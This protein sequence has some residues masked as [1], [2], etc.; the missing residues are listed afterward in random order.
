MAAISIEKPVLKDSDSWASKA[1]P[2]VDIIVPYEKISDGWFYED[3]PPYQHLNWFWKNMSD[4]LIHTNQRGIPVWDNKSIYNSSAYVS[5][6]N[7]LFQSFSENVQSEPSYDSRFW[8]PDEYMRGLKD[9]TID[10]NINEDLLVLMDSDVFVSRNAEDVVDMILDE[11]VDVTDAHEVDKALTFNGTSWEQGDIYSLFENKVNIGDL[12]D[13]ILDNPSDYQIL[14]RDEYTVG[15]DEYGN[16]LKTYG[17]VN[18]NIE[19]YAYASWKDVLEKPVT[20]QPITATDTDFGGIKIKV[21]E[22]DGN[23]YLYISTT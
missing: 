2:E 3:K 16:D 10:Q 19:D 21:E 11:I 13:V 22:V 4:F 7:A 15:K 9:T 6:D 1:D 18:K 23:N 12:D 20:F 14:V 17:W 8:A 5:Y